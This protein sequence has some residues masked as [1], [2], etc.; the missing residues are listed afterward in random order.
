MFWLK[1]KL[2]TVL[3][4]VD[5]TCMAKTEHG[6]S[7]DHL[8]TL[9]LARS[10]LAAV[11]KWIFFDEYSKGTRNE[12]HMPDFEDIWEA[13]SGTSASLLD[14]GLS[15]HWKI[16]VFSVYLQ[17]HPRIIPW[18][19][20]KLTEFSVNWAKIWPLDWISLLRLQIDQISFSMIW[21]CNFLTNTLV[22]VAQ[23][24]ETLQNL[25][26]KWTLLHKEPLK[27][28]LLTRQTLTIIKSVPLDKRIQYVRRLWLGGSG[29]NLTIRSII[30]LQK[31]TEPNFKEEF[32]SPTHYISRFFK[33]LF[34]NH[35]VVLNEI[36]GFA[37]VIIGVPG[38]V[39]VLT[40][41][42]ALALLYDMPLPQAFD[43]DQI[44]TL[45]DLNGEGVSGLEDPN[46]LHAK[47]P[48]ERDSLARPRR[49]SIEHDSNL[50]RIAAGQKKFHETVPLSGIFDEFDLRSLLGFS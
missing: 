45:L 17:L 5:I 21:Q 25:I 47:F 32:V 38:R 2:S 46:V 7:R 28:G 11:T 50:A 19:E 41:I 6:L 44:R 20:K 42:C 27:H 49:A 35:R 37:Q 3:A 22:F 48:I 30:T 26:L 24:S 13:V 34:V 9:L 33:F 12:G 16:S 8:Q 36:T 40:A 23:R 29:P 43:A 31:L 14:D 18:I 10:L 4:D 1:D 39:K 15:L